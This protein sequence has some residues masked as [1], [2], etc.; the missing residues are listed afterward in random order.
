MLV[1]GS[2]GFLLSASYVNAREEG[3]GGGEGRAGMCGS[4]GCTTKASSK[5]NVK[6]SARLEMGWGKDQRSFLAKETT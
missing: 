2:A 6:G 3:G 4:D 1:P 5:L